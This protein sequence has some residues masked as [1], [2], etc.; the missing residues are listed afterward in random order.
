MTIRVLVAEDFP[1]MRQAVATAIASGDDVRVVGQ[2]ADGQQALDLALRLRPDIVALDIH[3]P[4]MDGLEV[5]RHLREEL[6]EVRVLVITAS[7]RPGL[8]LT[9]L[10]A[11]A[12]GF[13][14]KRAAAHDLVEAVRTVHAGGSAIEPRLAPTLLDEFARSAGG[15]T[16]DSH[17]GGAVT[18]RVLTEV[19]RNVAR[20][21]ADGL[22]DREIGE[23]MYVSTRTVQNYLLRVR[24]KLG[25][26]RR[27]EIIRWVSDNRWV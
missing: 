12:N 5:L 1:L 16:N 15:P 11:G 8:F 3:M 9:A 21:V 14:S 25:V 18:P 27:S 13:I 19:E 26:Q 4:G 24:R 22:T 6:P 2:A 10:A 20:L 17:G 7:E 23:K